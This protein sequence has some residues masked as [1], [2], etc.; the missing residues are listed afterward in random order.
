MLAWQLSK[1]ERP[2]K[3]KRKLSCHY[4]RQIREDK[5]AEQKAKPYQ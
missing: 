1:P 4:E 3:R 5:D 2:I